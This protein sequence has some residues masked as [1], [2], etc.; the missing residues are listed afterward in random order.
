MSP[1]T[2]IDFGNLKSFSLGYKEHLKADFGKKAMNLPTW[3]DDIADVRNKCQ[4]FNPITKDQATHA[5]TTMLMILDILKLKDAGDEIRAIRD[6]KPA[7]PKK[8]VKVKK[9]AVGGTVPWFRNVQPHLDIR[10]GHLDESLFAANLSEVARE[11][12]REV[13]KNPMVFFSKTHPT[14]GLKAVLKRVV[15]GLNGTEE[16]ENRVIPL[17]TGFGGGKTH[18]LIALLHYVT[19]GRKVQTSGLTRELA[20]SVGIPDFEKANVAVFT[21]TTNDPTQGQGRGRQDH[22]YPL[23]RASHSACRG[24]R[25]AGALRH[26]KT[27]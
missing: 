20:D 6:G 10:Q 2:L 12:G 21:N 26:G 5:Y 9:T 1:E 18:V 7:A 11:G 14:A 25:E 22:P 3:F 17:Q 15:A 23:G 27:Q 13:Y 8:V 4:H 16:A 24:L 19:L